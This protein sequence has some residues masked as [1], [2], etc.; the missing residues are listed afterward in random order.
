MAHSC[1]GRS[2]SPPHLGRQPSLRW[3][4]NS[5]SRLSVVDEVQQGLLTYDLTGCLGCNLAGQ[6]P[7]SSAAEVAEE[8]M[9]QVVLGV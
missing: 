8:H 7:Q 5:L 9:V 2:P 6:S 4:H 1:G 3:A